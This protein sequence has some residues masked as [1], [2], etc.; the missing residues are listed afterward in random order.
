[1]DQNINQ[2][3]SADVIPVMNTPPPSVIPQTPMQPSINSETY[4]YSYAGFGIRLLAYIIDL[5]IN[6]ILSTVFGLIVGVVVTWITNDP[7]RT[8]SMTNQILFPGMG[9]LV[10]YLGYVLYSTVFLSLFSTTPG[11]YVC[12]LRVLGEDNTP[13]SKRSAFRRSYLQPFSMLFVGM[14]YVGM[15]KSPKKQAWHDTVAKTVVIHNPKVEH[16]FRT[17]LISIGIFL[18][19]IFLFTF[20]IIFKNNVFPRIKGD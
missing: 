1:M 15:I 20:A 5:I 9:Y 8:S 17:I 2:I 16:Y 14:G 11:K 18:A 3:P 6:S 13:L 10:N 19:L 4:H 12:K 7:T